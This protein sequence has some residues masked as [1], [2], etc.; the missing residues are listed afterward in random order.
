MTTNTVSCI[1]LHDFICSIAHSIYRY[2]VITYFV[3]KRLLEIFVLYDVLSTVKA[4]SHEC[5]IRTGQP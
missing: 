1:C 5:V 3:C 2:N 4:A